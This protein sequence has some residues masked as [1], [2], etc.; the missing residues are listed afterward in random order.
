MLTIPM[1]L[2]LVL[3]AEPFVLTFFTA[4]WA[5]AIPVMAAI[6]I[7]TLLRSLVFNSGSVYKAVGKPGLLTRLSLIQALISIPALWWTAVTYNTILAIAW[8]Q[9]LL[10][11][12]AGS[13]KLYMAARLVDIKLWDLLQTFLP[14]LAAGSV[15]ALAIWVSSQFLTDAIPVVALVVETAVGALVYGGTILLLQKEEV[16]RA[17]TVL[18]MAFLPGA[19]RV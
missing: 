6:S 2:G 15:M 9:V 18:R 16:L 7:Y 17:S 12:L 19:S 14:S 5:E 3:V 10:A 8:M 11:L 4:K 1:G 13:M